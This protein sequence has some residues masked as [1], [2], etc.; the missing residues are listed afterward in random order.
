MLETTGILTV[1]DKSKS[2]LKNNSE[3]LISFN[4][5]FLGSVCAYSSSSIPRSHAGFTFNT[6]AIEYIVL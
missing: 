1:S 3:L 5:T 4:S 6:L 2:G